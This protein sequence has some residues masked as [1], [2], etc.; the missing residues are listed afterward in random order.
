MRGPRI[1]PTLH[2]D[3]ARQL[4]LRE[5]LDELLDRDL[6]F[7]P[8]QVRADAPVDPEPEGCVPVLGT[9]DDELVGAVEEGRVAIG[10]RERQ[11]H[12]VV[13]PHR[14]A[15]EVVVVLD[16]PSHRHRRVGAQELL[17]R[18]QHH[19]RVVDERAEVV[20]MGGEVPDRRA[21]R[22]P[23]RVDPGD[24]QQHDRS[25]DVFV[26]ELVAVDLDVEQVGRQIVARVLDVLLDLP[27]DV[28]VEGLEAG[29]PLLG[30]QVDLLEH[31]MHEVTEDR[32]VL[33]REAEHAGDH[34]HRDALGV[35]HGGVDDGGARLDR[36]DAVEQLVA[37]RAD[38]GFP[39]VDRLR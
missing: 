8:G 28:L 3:V 35:L 23:R 22:A 13:R 6:Q 31:A 15:V 5:P 25:A 33:R 18:E 38:V 24:Q 20:G 11:Q 29:D 14:A 4:E 16:E 10:R 37:E 27:V 12:P 19:A 26:G 36:A 30:G 2:V 17:E 32:L 34:V 7:E 1:C 9:V 21:D 39:R